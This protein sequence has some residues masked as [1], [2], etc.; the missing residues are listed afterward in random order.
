MT[1]AQNASNAGRNNQADYYEKEANALVKDVQA[2]RERAEN[3]ET[4]TRAMRSY[5][6]AIEAG[7]DK[8]AAND[9]KA[10]A[11]A[12][13]DQCLCQQAGRPRGKHGVSGESGICRQQHRQYPHH[14]RRGGAE[15]SGLLEGVQYGVRS[16]SVFPPI[17]LICMTSSTTRATT[18]WSG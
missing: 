6:A 3:T 13:K 14:L 9:A 15:L 16:R 7:A 2:L 8:K 11:Q 12:Q 17:T 4:V 18:A 5:N 1:K 10:A